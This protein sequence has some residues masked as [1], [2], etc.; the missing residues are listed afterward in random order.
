MMAAVRRSTSRNTF[1]ARGAERQPDA[2]LVPALR[3]AMGDHAIQPDARQYHRD[4]REDSEQAR[5]GVPLGP[6]SGDRVSHGQHR[7][8][9]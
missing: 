8:Y 1:R 4:D 2:E 5:Q 7:R 9:R 6:G 3:H